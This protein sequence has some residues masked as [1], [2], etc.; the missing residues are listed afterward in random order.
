MTEVLNIG[1]ATLHHGDALTVLRTLAAQSVHCCVTSPPYYGLRDYGTGEW[2][3]GD[4]SCDHVV[5]EI[6]TGAG[7]AEA[8]KNFRGGGHKASKIKPILAAEQC[9]KCG[10]RRVGA[11][12]G[13]NPECDHQPARHDPDNQHLNGRGEI[14]TS[15]T[16]WAGRDSATYRDNC[17]RCGAQR[18][19]GQLG[20]EATPEEYVV[21]MVEVFHEL[22]RVLRD[23][24]T[25]WLNMG[26]SYASHGGKGAQGENGAIADR[27]A[28]KI[29]A[30]LRRTSA[31]PPAGLK[32]K[33][34]MGMP[35]RL[36]FALQADGWWLRSDIIWSKPNP[37]PESI[38]DRP[39][40]AHE[41]LFL[42]AKSQRYYYD[43]EAIRE[44]VTGNAHSR[45]HGLNPKAKTPDGW[46]TSRGDGAHG[47]IHRAG[48]EK[49][50]PG[51]R[52]RPRSKQNESFSAA[53]SGPLLA[54]RNKRSVWTVATQPY[55]GAHFAT[56][57]PKLIEP[58]ILAGCPTGGTVIDP[59]AGSGTTGV[60]CG[61]HGRQFVG[62]DLSG[63]Y[64]R[65]LAVDRVKAA[66][67][68][69]RLF[70]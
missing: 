37:M 1:D 61:Q 23:D 10:A 35:W 38:T 62:I 58:C 34:L 36:A 11:W 60:V 50:K 15:C 7:M 48:R 18:T 13:G 40:K 33:D 32:P 68:Q 9:P 59:F 25:L 49:G 52:H 70:A 20:L 19:P 14:G 4:S 67:A 39:T 42:M 44:P 29:G 45:G 64:L 31:E 26:D 41:Y 55:S 6:R 22:R 46:D 69:R 3:G 27:T 12:T 24:G 28:A 54:S 47:S 56:F 21:K 30:R 8:S 65:D 57:P 51:Y 53:I 66:F 17:P 43:Q 2:V 63:E 5:S 16:T